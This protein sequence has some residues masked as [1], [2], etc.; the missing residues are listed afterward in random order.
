VLS[1]DDERFGGSG[2]LE[3]AVFETVEGELFG[4]DQFVE[5]TLPALSV[6]FL[7]QVRPPIGSG[8]HRGSDRRKKGGKKG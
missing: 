7:K 6:L 3:E 1:S 4:R 8:K 2:S 5:L